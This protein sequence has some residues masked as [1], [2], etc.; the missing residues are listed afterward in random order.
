MAK[1]LIQDDNKFKV[2][3]TE[4]V[5][6]AEFTARGGAWPAKST[7][8]R[9]ESGSRG[10]Y[11]WGLRPNWNSFQGVAG[12]SAGSFGA[13]DAQK[14][15]E[16][17]CGRIARQDCPPHNNAESRMGKTKWHWAVS[18]Q[19]PLSKRECLSAAPRGPPHRLISRI[20]H[21][22]RIDL[23]RARASNASARSRLQVSAHARSPGSMSVRYAGKKKEARLTM[24]PEPGFR[25]EN[26]KL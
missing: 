21:S 26:S 13:Q 17:G 8:V 16:A 3:V 5:P 10:T 4:L 18:R 7:C 22:L 24:H 9:E 15:T 6:S 19:C 2:D 11:L 25:E 12:L 1:C 14:P 20:S 23:A